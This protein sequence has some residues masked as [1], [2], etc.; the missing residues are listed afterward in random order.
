[1]N[2]HASPAVVGGFV[3]AALALLVVSVLG[4]SVG[5]AFRTRAPVIVYFE[6]SVGGLNVG[7]PV[8]FRGI[9]IG[10]VKDVRID[11]TGVAIDP[12]QVR[13]PVLLEID[14]DRLRSQG[15]KLV[16]LRDR[17]VVQRLIDLGVRA[18]L[19]SESL[20][21]GARYVELDVIPDTPA[22]LVHDPRYPELPSIRSAT[23]AIPDRLQALLKKLEAIDIAGLTDSLRTTVDDADQLLR[24]EHLARAEA[25]LDAIT[26]ELQQTVS[27]L[28]AAARE[29]APTIT[30]VRGT[31][32]RLSDRIE[33]TLRELSEAVRSLRRLAD[34]LSRDPGAILRGGKQ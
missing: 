30:S 5:R 31:S 3:V 12:H 9:E 16:D 27:H 2:R 14:E 21:G 6:D 22:Q 1:M 15:A 33:T 18:K 10:S 24:S 19:A 25:R 13:I 23:E 11:I 7:A 32:E 17:K 26:D 4:L 34:Q 29:L 28:D 20:V 8:R